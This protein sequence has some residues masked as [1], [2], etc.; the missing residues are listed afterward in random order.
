MLGEQGAIAFYRQYGGF[1]MLL[2]TDDGRVLATPGADE[3]FTPDSAFAA[4]YTVLPAA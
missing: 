4:Q 1:E 3:H 2:V